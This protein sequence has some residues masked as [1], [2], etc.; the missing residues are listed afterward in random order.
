M[1]IGV[2]TDNSVVQNASEDFLWSGGI[3]DVNLDSTTPSLANPESGFVLISQNS[4]PEERRCVLRFTNGLANL[5]ASS[6]ID[7]AWLY[8]YEV[9][10]NTGTKIVDARRCLQNWNN[11][12]SE[13]PSWNFYNTLN[14]DAWDSPGASTDGVD[15]IATPIASVSWDDSNG[16]YKPYIDITSYIQ[17]VYDGTITTD[18]G[19]L[20]STDSVGGSGSF[21][22]YGSS[23]ASD[24]QRVELVIGFTETTPGPDPIVYLD[25]VN[26]LSPANLWVFD[27]DSTE[28]I[29]GLASTDTGVSYSDSAIC[30]GATN[31]MT[32]DGT[33]D[34]VSVAS[35][36]SLNGSSQNLRAIGGWFR[37]TAFQLPP[38]TIY[39]E[40]SS[41]DYLQF[42]MW[43]GNKMMFEVSN[44][45]GV[46]V[47]A[48]SDRIASVDRSYHIFGILEGDGDGNLVALFVDGVEQ[49]IT[50]PPNGEFGATSL[51][52]RGQAEFGDASGA[53]EVGQATVLLNA[54]VDG[55][56]NYWA[57]WNSG[58]PTST[59]VREILFE[60]GA[61]ADVVVSSQADVDA[62]AGTVRP[63]VPLC[64]RVDI[65][66]NADL[67]A[68]NIT[69][70]EL[71]SIH[72]QYLGN[73]TLNW[74]NINGSNASIGSTPNGGT[75]NFVNPSVLTAS[76]LVVGSEVRFY[77]A[78][79]QN[80]IAGVESSG[81]SFS[82]SVEVDFVDV[83][84]LSLTQLNLTFRNIDMTQG[85]VNIPVSQIPDRQYENPNTSIVSGTTGS[86]V[87]SSDGGDDIYIFNNDGTIT[88]TQSVLVT[89][90]IAAGGGGGGGGRAFQVC[91]G[92]GAGGVLTGTFTAEAGTYTLNVGLGGQGGTPQSGGTPLINQ[93][94]SGED[95]SIVGTN[96]PAV[97]IGGGRGDTQN[98]DEHPSATDSP[99]GGSGGG[100][101]FG[102][103]A[104]A[105]TVGQGNDG[106]QA[107][108]GG[109]TAEGGLGTGDDNGGA[110][111][112][113][114]ITGTALE[115]G[116]GGDGN[117]TGI[118]GIDG[119]GDGGNAN[120]TTSAVEVKGGDGGDGV[121]ILRFAA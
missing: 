10:S 18:N 11:L 62:I 12:P 43:A 115:Y 22:V 27:G 82:S 105:G 28:S 45:A 97:A 108:G 106:N 66:G 73:G 114:S 75:L 74:T 46:N 9:F 42:V 38:K 49:S 37:T 88:F 31:C 6:T 52:S 47:Q 78:G 85:D 59:Q 63:N 72:V 14:S 96:A 25:E 80:E 4:S 70:D 110:G 86:P 5:P 69:F 23:E 60:K 89:Y 117:T 112:I 87:I 76:P 101:W 94:R 51:N 3:E 95:S 99:D 41:G 26:S 81:A 54:P 21:A 83:R 56:Y 64:I 67:T 53:T 35:D 92:G 34:R 17:D 104:G 15:R 100:A 8:I 50:E 93:A 30:E 116:R 36:V 57:S 24:G 77:E 107:T 68:D 20:L 84:I 65:D 13:Q 120:Y 118:D 71:A 102:N 103:S 111:L 16:E 44:S 119:R 29:L 90:L 2:I 7:Y 32:T 121:I 61:L 40:G 33:G 39:R 79:T 109:A 48:F 1:P 91:S 113:S 98:D 55:N 19:I 58:L